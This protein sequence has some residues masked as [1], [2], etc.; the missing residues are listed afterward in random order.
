MNLK[1]IRR[2]KTSKVGVWWDYQAGQRVDAPNANFCIR[3]AERDNPQHRASLARLQ[4]ENL[5][6]LR[7]GGELAMSCWAKLATRS[8]AESVLVDW[9][10][11][12]DDDGKP[13][14]YSVD[15]AIELL[16]DESLWPL[17]NF[18]EDAAGVVRSYRVEQ[19]EQA[20]GN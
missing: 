4:L 16:E 9:S 5:D 19:E 18:I 3:V 13:I 15:K 12:E 7:V 11:L 8:L 10:G 17:R 14:A 20:K 1:N 6:K 2:D